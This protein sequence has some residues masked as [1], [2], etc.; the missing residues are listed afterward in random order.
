MCKFGTIFVILSVKVKHKRK[1]NMKVLDI[2]IGFSLLIYGFVL[3]FGGEKFLIDQATLN[4]IFCF[5]ISGL[6]ART[7]MHNKRLT[8]LDGEDDY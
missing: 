8:K 2:I 4:S 3:F 6:I 7:G 5:T 1:M